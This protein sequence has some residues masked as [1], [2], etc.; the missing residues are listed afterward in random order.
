LDISQ[1]KGSKSMSRVTWSLSRRLMD[2]EFFSSIL[3]EISLLQPARR[4]MS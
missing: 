4:K 3:N 2:G 1:G